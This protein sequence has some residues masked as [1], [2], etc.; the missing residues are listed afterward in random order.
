M[1]QED[2]IE[3]Q[4]LNLDN[5]IELT[6]PT[7]PH[8]SLGKKVPEK[9]RQVLV[10]KMEGGRVILGDPML[11]GRTGKG[12]H[13]Q[14]CSHTHLACC[15]L[16]GDFIWGLY[17]QSLRCSYCR[18]TC[19]YRCRAFIQLDCIPLTGQSDFED[20]T[21]EKDTNVDEEIDWGKCELSVSEVVQKVKEYNAQVNGN[22]PMVL[23]RDGS[24]SGFIKVHLRLVCSGSVHQNPKQLHISSHTR[25]CEVIQAL[26]SVLSQAHSPRAALYER[27]RYLGQVRVRRLEVAERPL[28]LR[29][30]AGPSEESL[31]LELQEEDLIEINWDAFTLPELDNFLRILQREE[32]QHV[33]QIVQRYGLSR[34]RLQEALACSAPG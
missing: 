29:L 25:V 10:V 5:H 4:D 7:V 11:S 2:L 3:L 6:T 21:V 9:L 19:H 26:Q 28:A 33:K 13:F 34:L 22:L 18:F 20:G 16:C 15:D 17:K 12:H 14:P 8:Q 24:Y 32:E 1:S 27:T 23:D 31:S 30:C